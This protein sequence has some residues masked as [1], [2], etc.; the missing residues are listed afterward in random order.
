MEEDS[1]GIKQGLEN[2]GDKN[3]GDEVIIEL[4]MLGAAKDERCA[5]TIQMTHDHQVASVLPGGRDH[6]VH[7]LA[8][9]LGQDQAVEVVL[10]TQ[11]R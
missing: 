1:R 10:K 6:R 8:L 2:E 9:A 5:L 11:L 4:D 3:K 7:V